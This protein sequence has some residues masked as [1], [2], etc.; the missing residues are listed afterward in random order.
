MLEW[1]F[2]PQCGGCDA[3]G[4]G[5]CDGCLP[6]GQKQLS[7][8]ATLSV[9]GLGEYA[10]PLR[11]AI[12]A[13]KDGRRDVA[14]SMGSRLAALTSA[15]TCLVPVPTTKKRRSVRGFDGAE[16]IADMCA[17]ASGA[18]AHRLLVQTAGDAQ[19]GRGRKDRLAALGRFSC[20]ALDL[21][22][23]EFVLLD[24]VVTTGST[25]EDCARALRGANGVVYSAIVV[26]ITRG[27]HRR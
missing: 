15:Q 21:G 22:R 12:L 4:T 1:F 24:D 11:Q 7:S 13:L 20:N 27:D 8:T 16:L 18:T 26:A 10:G 17:A 25:L 6:P 14:R 2:P 5:L 3:F 19:R 23:R 9:T